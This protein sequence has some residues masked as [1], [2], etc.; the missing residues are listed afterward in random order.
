MVNPRGELYRA[1]ACLVGAGW[2]SRL[3]EIDS[4]APG[5]I[6][7][8]SLPGLLEHAVTNVPFYRNLNLAEPR[9]D[10]FP[11]LTRQMLRTQF[12]QLKRDDI[13]SRRW[14]RASTGGSTGEPVW[15]IQ[16]RDFLQWDYAT[17]MYYINAFYGIRY[18]EY[19]RSRRVAI[20]HRRRQRAGVDLVKNLAVRL[21]GQVLYIEPYAILSEELL[22]EYLRR[23]NRHRPLLI[24][25]FAGTVFE[26]ARHARRMGIR[27]HSPRLI[28]A[29][30][31]M[32]FAPMREAISEVFG[33][34]VHNMY[35]AAEVGRIA[36]ECTEGTFHV[37]SF[38]NRVEVLDADGS[39]T[40]PGDVG[41]V[42]I[43][44]LHNRAMPLI[45]YEIGDLA[46]VSEGSCSCGSPLP[47]LSEVR[48]RVIDHF[49][50]P[51]GRLV[52]GG[53]FIA[54]F[55]EHDWITGLHVLQEDADRIRIM[56]TKVPDR[57]VS[58]V[59]TNAL[60]RNVRRVMGGSCEVT[61]EEVDVIPKSPIGK[62]LHARSLVWE[63][64]TGLEETRGKISLSA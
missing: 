45:R 28:I 23:I 5:E 18:C 48:G 1:A 37:F 3:R 33:C 41:R 19:L 34:P 27:M 57:V 29:S 13:E 14:R 42:V 20:W 11:L 21:L 60:A 7:R 58:E 6:G 56:Y 25:A 15:V 64:R 26:L 44:S 12:D 8:K 9:L 39:P 50:R 38:V 17:D 36:A 30:V 55:Y 40:T 54:M 61:W 4:A 10:A 31:E 52:F 63:E 53:N 51:D 59:V 46:R 35:G 43:T 49:V 62:H 24:L 22:T 16:D 47:V 32:L 2:R